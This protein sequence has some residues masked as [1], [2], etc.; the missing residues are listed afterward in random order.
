MT[1]SVFTQVLSYILWK[2]SKN[3]YPLLHI[4]TL[5]EY[6]V[7]LRFYYSILHS[8]L[9]KAVFVL[10]A[11][12]VPV[13]FVIDSFF[14]ESI[15]LYNSYSRSIEALI[16]IFLAMSWY[17]KLVSEDPKE[18]ALLVPVKFINSALFIYFSGSIT[19]FSF[20]N[21]ISGRIAAF[22]LSIWTLHTLLAVSLY[23]LITL[24][25]WKYRKH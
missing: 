19:L 1:A 21:S 12:M 18:P 6:L 22:N 14:L 23:V 16:F 24:G 25:L 20:A 13:F 15:Y 5:V 9:P 4:Y 8:F 10:L 3:N 11:T 17:V 7:L 2:Q